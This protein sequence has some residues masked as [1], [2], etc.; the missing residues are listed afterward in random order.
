MQFK[1]FC[2][3]YKSLY[4]Y[5][6]SAN[7]FLFPIVRLGELQLGFMR[8]YSTEKLKT[9]SGEIEHEITFSPCSHASYLTTLK[10]K[11]IHTTRKVV[12]K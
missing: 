9:S 4:V 7:N 8:Q 12:Q 2:A 5:M 11:K 1:E 10:L 3:T 6:I